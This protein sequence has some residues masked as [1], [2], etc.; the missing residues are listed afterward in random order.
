M[1]TR[2]HSPFLRGG[3][4]IAGGMRGVFGGPPAA[5]LFVH[6]GAD[7]TVRLAT[8]LD[9]YRRAPW[10]KGFVTLT[11]Q[12]H[13]EYLGPGRPGG[14]PPWVARSSPPSGAAR[15]TRRRS[16]VPFAL[17]APGQLLLVLLIGLPALYVLVLS[18]THSRFGADTTWAGLANYARI[19]GDPA[20]GRAFANTLVVVNVVKHHLDEPIFARPGSCAQTTLS[21][22]ID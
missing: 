11:G 21:H 17:V 13:G 6:G 2:G 9:A 3:I 4:V 16:F 1:F 10:P 8:G 12:R 14:H 19:L 18:F 15:L 5:L 22:R 7:P 20:F